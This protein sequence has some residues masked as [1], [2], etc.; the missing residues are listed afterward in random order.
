MAR[1][2]P[3]FGREFERKV[4]EA[5]ALSEAV[6]TA[7]VRLASQRG[8]PQVL[9]IPKVEYVYEVAYLR[10]FLAWEDVLERS[11]VRYIA[12]FANSNGLQS[13]QPGVTYAGSVNDAQT[14]LYNGHP[15]LLW[16]SPSVIVARSQRFFVG[17]LH[18][19]VILSASSNVASYAAV[20]H[21]VAHGQEDA[22]R[23]FDTATMTL[24]G[25]R[26]KGAKA[27]AFLRDWHGTLVPRQRWIAVIADELIGLIKQ[28]VP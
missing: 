16:H 22:R 15:Y 3:D 28:I 18:E 26:Y 10:M 24:G 11:L 14:Q 4:T 12:G 25:K 27:G 19:T 2:M 9:S 5:L 1:Q 23:K 20:R 7:R 8:H 13:L 6:E 21:R 17:G